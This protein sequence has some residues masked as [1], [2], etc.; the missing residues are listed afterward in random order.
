MSSVQAGHM[1]VDWYVEGRTWICDIRFGQ[2]LYWPRCVKAAMML[3]DDDKNSWH[4]GPVGRSVTRDQWGHQ[5]YVAI[6]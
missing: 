1:G 6:A 5:R 3:Y 4:F 2:S